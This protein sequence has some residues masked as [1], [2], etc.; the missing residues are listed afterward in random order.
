VSW[1]MT[2]RGYSQRRACGLVGIAPKT[3]RYVSTR[4]DDA[5][6]RDRLKALADAR[7]RFGYRRLHI[8][9]QREGVEVNHSRRGPWPLRGRVSPEGAVPPL[10]GREADRAPSRRPKTGA[11]DAGA[12]DDP[13]GP[14]P[15]AVDRL[16]AR[17]ADRRPAVPRL[18]ACRRLQPGMP[19]ARRVRHRPRTG[20]G[21]MAH[22]RSRGGGS[23]ATWTA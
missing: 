13:P 17:R 11:G 7:R 8:L 22:P 9:L 23:P 3:F 18:G 21:A 2:E 20:G 6:L 14:E 4:P 5:E 16:P 1:A 10:P 15:E 19:R 12:D